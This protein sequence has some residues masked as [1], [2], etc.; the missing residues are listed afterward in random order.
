MFL[1]ICI[2]FIPHLL[3]IKYV[4]SVK[5]IVLNTVIAARL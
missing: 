2:V 3:Q 5:M 4:R 1:S